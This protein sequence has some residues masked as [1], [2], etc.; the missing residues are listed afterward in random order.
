MSKINS[1]VFDKTGTITQAEDMSVLYNEKL[2][3]D[4]DKIAV[5]SIVRH[6]SH[7][8][9]KILYKLWSEV[10]LF[11]IHDFKE[12]PGK[13]LEAKIGEDNYKLGSS[14][15]TGNKNKNSD[16]NSCV[17]LQKNDI[18]ICKFT[19]KSKYRTGFE[20]LI[21]NLSPHYNLSLISGDNNSEEKY[22]SSFFKTEQ[23]HFHQLPD[24]KMNYIKL[25]QAKGNKVLMI[26]DGLND[27]SALL[28]SNVG[29]ADSDNLKNFSTASD[30]IIDGSKFV[31][32]PAILKYAKA[33]YYIILASFTISFLLNFVGV[34]VAVQGLLSPVFADIFMPVCSITILLFTTS[35][36]S[37]VAKWLKL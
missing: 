30:V 10:Q 14:D 12:F 18:D 9:S 16:T 35:A 20:T 13:G 3:S 28:Q 31:Q 1:I 21:K 2:L 11:Q 37:L 8:L 19:F 24:D 17:Y 36:T 4:Y 15:F 23:L 33:A 5:K 29:I 32:L 26:G 27:A 7:P 34:S 25:E 6:S 22:L